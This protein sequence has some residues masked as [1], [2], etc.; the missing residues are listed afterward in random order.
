MK[1]PVLA[2]TLGDP[3]GIGPE[4]T[5]KALRKLDSRTATYVLFGTR[6]ALLRAARFAPGLSFREIYSDSFRKK[7]EHE[8]ELLFYDVGSAA[9][10]LFYGKKKTGEVPAFK[11]GGVSRANASLAL[12]SLSEA[13]RLA[14]EGK[15]HAIVTAP[16][17]KTTQRLLDPGFTGHTEFLAE[18][19]KTKKF[20][21]MFVGPRLKVTLATVHVAL[22]KV[23]AQITAAGVVDKIMLTH[24]F[25]KKNMRLAKPRL[26]VCALN[27]HGEE[28][29][30][31]ENRTIA[32]AVKKARRSGID[33]SGP[34]SADQLFYEA[35][36]GRYDALISMYHDQALAPF[37]MVHFNDGVNVTLGLPFVRTSP[38]HGTAF[39]IA[40][41]GKADA[42]SMTASIDLAR[43]LASV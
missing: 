15:I 18:K 28:T 7:T 21:M 3:G 5:L 35:Y 12:A 29:G 22:K 33:V 27:P 26:A 1:K 2:L 8:G 14:C 13:A 23:S 36:E 40:W 17:N 11:V 32:P 43:R 16:L 20:A 30:D 25:L 10:A 24:A 19:A 34:F 39:D 4:V 42:S 37:K 41:K 31:E 38:D 9:A 6:G